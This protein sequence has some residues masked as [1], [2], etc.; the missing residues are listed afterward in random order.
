MADSRI[1]HVDR[2]SVVLPALALA[3]VLGF[4]GFHGTGG[5]SLDLAVQSWFWGGRDWLIPKDSGWFHQLAYTGPKVLLYAFALGL[6]WAI[7][8]PDRSPAWLGRRRAIYLFLSLAVVSLVCTQLRSITHMATPRDLSIYGAV[9]PNAWEHLLLF[10][11]KPALYPSHAFPAGHA[12][13]GFALLAL[14]FAWGTAE[15]R[16]R[17]ALI[18]LVYGAGMGVYQIARGEHFLSHTVATAVLAWLIVAVLARWLKPG[19]L[20]SPN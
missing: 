17:G 7:A 10:D 13:G 19:E 5:E 15:A 14:A 8:F 20:S 12:S 3:V 16:R 11:A 1:P 4:F 6:L 18:G 2:P 9:A